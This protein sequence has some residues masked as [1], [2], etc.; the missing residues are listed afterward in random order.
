[1]GAGEWLAG[2]DH[3]GK[4]LEDP[5][6]QLGITVERGPGISQGLRGADPP[7]E[8]AQ[9]DPLVELD[10]DGRRARIAEPCPAI[11]DV[12]LEAPRLRPKKLKGN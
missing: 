1:M 6:A 2:S 8:A 4:C 9:K 5:T 7:G 11:K 10:R 12:N 3:D